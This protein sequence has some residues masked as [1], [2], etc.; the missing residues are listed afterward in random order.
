MVLTCAVLA[1]PAVVFAG[2]V[3]SKQPAEQPQP[4]PLFRA[5]VVLRGALGEVTV[6]VAIRPK[7]VADEGLEGEYFIFGRSARVLLAG[8]M[9]GD[10][11]FLEES[12]NGT[13]ISGQWE[14]T[15]NGATMAGMWTSADGDTT[16]AFSLHVLSPSAKAAPV[17]KAAAMAKK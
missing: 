9:E 15:L 11:L 2:E 16:K 17:S 3:A 4:A 8:E 5:P 13:D 7:P 10:K 14:G 12:E 6:Q 1:L